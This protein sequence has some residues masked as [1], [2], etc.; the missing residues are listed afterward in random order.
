MSLTNLKD[1]YDSFQLPAVK[2]I[3][4]DFTK[5]T[6][7]RYLLVIPTGGGKTY[8]AVKSICKLFDDG[9]IDC[10][11]DQVL[12]TAHRRELLG[13]AKTTFNE[14]IEIKSTSVSL[15]KNILF[16]MISGVNQELTKNTN[17]K[18]VVIDEAH[19]GAAKSYNPIFN[20][21]KIGVLGLTA[22]PSRHDGKPLEFERESFSIGFP[23][24][25]KKGI[26]LKPEIILLEG[27]K[28]DISG[29]EDDDLEI[30]NNNKRNQKIIN[31]LLENSDKYKK[32]IVY[33]GTKKHAENLFKILSKT[34]LNSK[35]ESICYIIGNKNSRNQLREEFIK[36]EKKF[37]RSILINVQV[38]SEGYDDPSVNTIIM[39]SPSKSKLYYMQAL[40]R[41]VRRNPND[42]LK[43]AYVVEVV[44]EL[45]NIRYRI[46]NRWLYADIS[47][48]LEPAVEDLKF[49]NTIE[50]KEA[51]IKLYK[52][53]KTPARY[54][55]FPEYDEDTRYSILFFKQYIGPNDYIGFP[56]VITNDNRIKVSNM[57]NFISE[58]MR[59]FRSK[60]YHYEAVFRMIGSDGVD[61]IKDYNNRR[62]IFDAMTNASATCTEDENKLDEFIKIGYPWLTF[63]S[64]NYRKKEIDVPEAWMEFIEEMINRDE[65]LE[66][67]ISKSYEKISILVRFPLP[68][69]FFIGKI[70]TINEFSEVKDTVA[71]LEDLKNELGSSDHIHE[72]DN[73]VGK[74]IL[75]IEV[76]LSKS[77]PLIVRDNINY[78]LELY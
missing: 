36:T 12:W 16:K 39:A 13:Q 44:D 68:L 26:I 50:F 52:K 51:F 61:L 34:S 40:G 58:R 77:L 43:K 73:V 41:A 10:D 25:V 20:N 46:D 54:Q 24:L 18:I 49:S 67:L 21:N 33:V 6:T 64:L 27:G 72:V 75:P 47:D 35:Y 57:F 19:H 8:T 74:A 3:F 32:V 23:D 22:T 5:K 71:K 17:I 56:V 15:K 9:T 30:L 29:F 4:S 53:F 28:Y 38:L 76:M 65:I 45:P 42:P 14:L 11:T 69:G 70:L 55:E 2:A 48:A 78:Y 1:R 62:L 66:L 63:V 59:S 37:N 60:K 31:E 7:G